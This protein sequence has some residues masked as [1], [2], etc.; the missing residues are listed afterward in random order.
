MIFVMYSQVLF[1]ILCNNL[2]QLLYLM[3]FINYCIGSF[4]LYFTVYL[5]DYLST[6]LNL[7]CLWQISFVEACF[8]LILHILYLNNLFYRSTVRALTEE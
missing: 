1:V 5:L 6:I 8:I 4:Y 7:I 2:P 3:D